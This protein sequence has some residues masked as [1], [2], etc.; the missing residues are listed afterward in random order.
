MEVM[1]EDV[2]LSSSTRVQMEGDEKSAG[3]SRVWS[4]DMASTSTGMQTWPVAEKL[5]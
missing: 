3:M 2:E 5:K 1:V 4:R